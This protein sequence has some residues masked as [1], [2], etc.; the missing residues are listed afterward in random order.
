MHKHPSTLRLFCST[1]GTQWTT[2]RCHPYNMTLKFN[3]HPDLSPKFY[4]QL[5][6][7]T[8]HLTPPFGCLEKLSTCPKWNFWSLSTS[9]QPFLLHWWPFHP[10]LQLLRPKTLV[11]SFTLSY[12]PHFNLLAILLAINWIQ[13][14]TFYLHCHHSGLNYSPTY[15]EWLCYLLCCPLLL[16]FYACPKFSTRE[17]E[18]SFYNLRTDH[19]TS[20]LTFHVPV[21]QNKSSR[22]SKGPQSP[23]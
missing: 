8:A 10:K 1:L 23:P 11:S 16:C 3:L 19:I 12:V 14:Q 17:P 2:A 5:G 6:Y 20:L 15:P 13:T 7:T 22:L 9:T 18:W 4:T 21:P